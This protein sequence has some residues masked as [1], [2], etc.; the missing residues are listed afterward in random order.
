MRETQFQTDDREEAMTHAIILSDESYAVVQRNA[1]RRGIDPEALLEQMIE[2]L[3]SG[4]V[5]DDDDDLSRALGDTEEEIAEAKLLV[6][7]LFPPD[8]VTDQSH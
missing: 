3:P 7:K 5:Y 1:E 8:D 6:D 2:R 4:I